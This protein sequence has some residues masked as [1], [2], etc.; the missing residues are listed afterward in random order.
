LP[1]RLERSPRSAEIAGAA[2]NR[3][4]DTLGVT[5]RDCQERMAGRC[6]RPR[7]IGV[8]GDGRQARA[9][10]LILSAS[11]EEAKGSEKP[12]HAER[13]EIQPLAARAVESPPF[14]VSGEFNPWIRLIASKT[15]LRRIPAALAGNS[16][17]GF[18]F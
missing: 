7:Q 12:S 4:T 1:D 2:V 10:E 17:S 13:G 15:G 14:A 6:H 16:W 8:R 9:T 11:S 5:P 18:D 3:G